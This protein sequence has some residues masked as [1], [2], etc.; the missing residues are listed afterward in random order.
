MGKIY[1]TLQSFFSDVGLPAEPLDETNTILRINDY[2]GTNGRWTVF[3]Q[4]LE[5]NA[6]IVFYSY[7]PI[8]APKEKMTAMAEFFTLANY[9]L[10]IGNFELDMKDGEI[11]FK[12]SMSVAGIEPPNVLLAQM[13]HFNTVTLD[14]YLPGIMAVVAGG[15]SPT[16]AINRV[17]AAEYSPPVTPSGEQGAGP[18]G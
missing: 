5:Q 8:N 7:S 2:V 13:V 3:A 18:V 14:R 11:R 12:T 6:Q 1:E 15:V 16:E 4:A 17:E 9:G 10:V